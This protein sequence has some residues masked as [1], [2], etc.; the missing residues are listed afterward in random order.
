[1]H[2]FLRPKPPGALRGMTPEHLLVGHGAGVHGPG[3]TEGLE[4]A[5]AYARRDLPRA[6]L[7]MPRAMRGR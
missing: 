4:R 6:L 2:L 7:A 1:M 5:Y 3:A